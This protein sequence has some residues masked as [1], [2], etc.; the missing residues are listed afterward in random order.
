MDRAADSGSAGW[1]FKSSLPHIVALIILLFSC[2][3][4]FAGKFEPNK[5]GVIAY[6][7]PRPDYDSFQGQAPS[8]IISYLKQLASSSQKQVLDFLQQ[9][10]GEVD[11]IISFWTI[12]AI[13]IM[14]TQDVVSKLAGRGD[15]GRIVL[16]CERELGEPILFNAKDAWDNIGAIRADEVHSELGIDGTGVIV[17]GMD[18]GV[19][20]FHPDLEGNF[21]GNVEPGRVAW[22]DP[23]DEYPLYPQDGHGHGTHT[24]G[25]VC[26]QGG[27]GVAPGA[28]WMAVKIFRD[29]STSRDFIIHS[30]FQFIADPDGNAYTDDFPRLVNN[31]WGELFCRE[32]MLYYDDVRLWRVL[33]IIPVFAIGND[34]PE[35]SSTTPPG[36]YPNVIAAG[37]TDA[38]NNII[39]FSSRGPAPSDFPWFGATKPDIAAPGVDILSAE[40]GTGGYTLMSGTSMASPHIAGTVALMLSANPTLDY[41]DVYRI[42]SETAVDI[43]DTGMDNISG[44]GLVD[45]YRAVQL[46]MEMRAPR[47]YHIPITDREY[48][49]V[50]FVAT[51]VSPTSP[52]D[53]SSVRLI[54]TFS[55]MTDTIPFT[56]SGDSFFCEL[57][58][59]GEVDVQYFIQAADSLGRL[60]YLPKSAPDSVFSFHIGRDTIPPVI[61]FVPIDSVLSY[62]MFPQSIS[63]EVSDNGEIDSV[64]IELTDGAGTRSIPLEYDSLWGVYSG[65]IDSEAIGEFFYRIVAMDEASNL[66]SYPADWDSLCVDVIDDGTIDLLWSTV[67]EIPDFI[68]P[69]YDQE[70]WSIIEVPWHCQVESVKTRVHL[71]YPRMRNI[72]AVLYSPSGTEVYL[73]NRTSLTD[74]VNIWYPDEMSEDGPGL[75]SDFI[76]ED[77]AGEWY[78][79][80]AD[81]SE[82]YYGHY[83]TLFE[84][85]LTLFCS[86]IA[87]VEEKTV[88][89]EKF[90]LF[91]YPNPF[92]S[93]IKILYSIPETEKKASLEI[94]NILGERVNTSH[95]KPG[96]HTVLWDAR[97]LPSGVYLCLLRGKTTSASLK[98]FLL[99]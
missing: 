94:Y 59:P 54:L 77:A 35:V 66:S 15:V 36:N 17:G 51:V 11:T 68:P 58:F 87:G 46:A 62:L 26:G 97:E 4:L 99:R 16:D 21:L 39:Y 69:Y 23:T 65:E 83:G 48:T 31:S 78:L 96:I 45:A 70:T 80:V 79:Y 27:I 19:D 44:Y 32:G 13:Y 84:W 56:P 41:D 14:T 50:T 12:N 86:P 81:R 88:L 18:S 89:P 37:A 22:F 92:N 2:F 55:G 93:A 33:G 98:I 38:S 60:G 5:I 73:H 24:M 85:E 20:G 61:E 63:V 49:T 25:T 10:R 28:L 57:S 42:L 8:W 30:G 91:A 75:L 90:K 53:T 95:A 6:I 82:M 67:T 43:G 47:I 7:L 9:N 74:S 52:L 64:W 40:A 71:T 34:G 72:V 1:R 29:N 76:C 3:P